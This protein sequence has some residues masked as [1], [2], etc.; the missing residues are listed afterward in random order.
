MLSVCL[1]DKQK[2]LDKDPAGAQRNTEWGFQ[3]FNQQVTPELSAELCE[4]ERKLAFCPSSPGLE[5]G[6]QETRI[7]VTLW[8]ACGHHPEP[9]TQ[10][11][12]YIQAV[13]VQ[14]L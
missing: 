14:R 8:T 13:I 3:V 1:P 9:G 4:G 11:S 5:I 2:S 6:N 10:T 12:V 7:Q